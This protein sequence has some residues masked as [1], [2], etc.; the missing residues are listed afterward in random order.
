MNREIK[1]RQVLCQC[2]GEIIPIA[3]EDGEIAF[4]CT[5]CENVWRIGSNLPSF[6]IRDWGGK[7]AQEK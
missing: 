4:Y 6:N 3:D 1:F 5:F 7:V 2:G